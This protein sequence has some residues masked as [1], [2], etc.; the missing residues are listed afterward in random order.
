ME[1]EVKTVTIPLEE[2]IELRRNA[3]TNMYLLKELGELTE[4]MSGIERRLWELEK[5][6]LN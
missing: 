2:Y 5:K 1:N 6:E 3:E 4:R